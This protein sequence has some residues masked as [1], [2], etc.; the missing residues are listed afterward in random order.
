MA[1]VPIMLGGGGAADLDQITA[2]AGQILEPYVGVD[3]NGDAITGAIQSMGAITY[4]PSTSAQE[5]AA[6]KYLSGK[7]TIAAVSQSGIAAANI[8]KGVTV[9]VKG[10]DNTLY[11]VVGTFEGYVPAAAD[12]YNRG[13][14]GVP[15]H[16]I[17]RGTAGTAAIIANSDSQIAVRLGQKSAIGYTKMIILG[18]SMTGG[19]TNFRYKTTLPTDFQDGN[20][21]WSNYDYTPTKIT[22]TLSPDAINIGNAYWTFRINF[23]SP[24]GTITRIYFE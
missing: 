3:G 8:K 18:T 4:K 11:S 7:Q 22:Y 6:G 20:A 9:W 1:N 10:G 13:S 2:G 12:F 14:W 15:T 23:T 17:D 21:A 5:I 19:T 24:S 16:Y